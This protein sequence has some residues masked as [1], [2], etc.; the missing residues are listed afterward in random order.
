[1]VLNV[2]SN[3]LLLVKVLFLLLY[4]LLRTGY[5]Q[6]RLIK[7]LEDLIIKYDGTNRNG[8]GIIVQTVYGENG[9]N[10]AIQSEVKLDILSMDNKTIKEKFGLSDKQAKLKLKRNLKLRVLD[11]WSDKIC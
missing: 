9:I 2:S 8:R 5:I 3:P 7:G 4:L 10:Q 1:M 6:R 11:V